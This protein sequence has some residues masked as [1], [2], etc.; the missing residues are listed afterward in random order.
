MTTRIKKR[1]LD[2]LPAANNSS[3]TVD[4]AFPNG[5]KKPKHDWTFA[6][7]KRR[8]AQLGIPH[9]VTEDKGVT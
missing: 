1:K 7:L 8:A 2:E 5:K 9:K 3:E 6:E 4:Q